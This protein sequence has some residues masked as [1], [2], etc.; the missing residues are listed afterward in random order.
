MGATYAEFP[1]SCRIAAP[2]GPYDGFDPSLVSG[3]AGRDTR[4]GER[5]HERL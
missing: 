5:V 2:V 1:T 3:F 4:S